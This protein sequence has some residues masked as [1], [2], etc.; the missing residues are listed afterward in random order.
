MSTVPSPEYAPEMPLVAGIG[1][2]PVIQWIL[3]P[4]LALFLVRRSFGPP[5]ASLPPAPPG[6]EQS[7][8]G[9]VDP[10]CGRTLATEGA[11]Q[12]F[13]GTRTRYFCSTECRRAFIT[14]SS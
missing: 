9:S 8:E 7:P 6:G 2:A 11:N 1:L 10:T 4:S 13:D 12:F 3:I 14:S 5:A